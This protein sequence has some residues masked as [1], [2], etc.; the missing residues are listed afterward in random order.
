MSRNDIR[1]LGWSHG[2]MGRCPVQPSTP[3]GSDHANYHY[4]TQ[5][6][7]KCVLNDSIPTV[8]VSTAI[9]TTIL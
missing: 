6:R 2:L 7:E 5:V 9:E 4:V 8:S 1:V 3:L